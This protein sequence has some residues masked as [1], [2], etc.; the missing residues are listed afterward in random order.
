M[1]SIDMSSSDELVTSLRM[2]A[3]DL[4]AKRSILDL[5]ETLGQ[6]VV[7]AVQ[8]VPGAD[9]GGIS[10]TED[11]VVSSRNPTTPLVT[12]LDQLQTEL[13][14]GPCIT[15]IDEPADDGVVLAQDLAGE[16]AGRWPRFAPHAVDAGYRA[17]LSTQLTADKSMRAALNL[18]AREPCA[19]D[20]EARRTA[21]LFGV[22]AA[23]LLYGHEHVGHLQRA[24]DSRDV[25]GQ[26]KG[27]LMERFTVSDDEA[28]Q[29]LVRSSQETNMKLVDVAE[30]LRSEAHARRE[31]KQTEAASEN[32]ET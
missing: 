23:I 20:Q 32:R 15:A 19:F 7:A 1:S 16:D 4:M 31:R 30:W 14:E 28:F 18:Y 5:D 22:Q 13:Y 10:F 25:I 12:D 24:V 26:A 6:I 8:T 2:A 21:G 11:G 29:M 27:I 17:I 3:R 9:S